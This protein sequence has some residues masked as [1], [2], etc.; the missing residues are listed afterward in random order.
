MPVSTTLFVYGTLM[1]PAIF[2][3][4]TGTD[5]STSPALLRGYAR[6]RVVGQTFPVVVEEE[7]ACV[8]GKLCLGVSDEALA[9]LDRFEGV[10][11]G[12]YCRSEVTVETAESVPIQAITYTAG[13]NLGAVGELWEPGSGEL[14]SYLTQEVAPRLD[15]YRRTGNLPVA[16]SVLS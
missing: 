6:R 7:S 13:P 12:L 8:E 11:D 3:A 2:R 5:V 1:F 16:S 10:A 4:V 15:F 14:E 9:L